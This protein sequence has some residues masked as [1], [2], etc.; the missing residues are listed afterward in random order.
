MLIKITN[1]AEDPE[2][3]DMQTS[4][5]QHIKRVDPEYPVPAVIVS[6]SGLSQ[7]WVTAKDGRKHILRAMSFLP[8]MC[9]DSGVRMREWRRSQ[10]L[11]YT[12]LG[13]T[14]ETVYHDI[15]PLVRSELL[16]NLGRSLA[17]LGRNMRGYFHQKAKRGKCSLKTCHCH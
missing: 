15:D 11:A 1:S 12:C 16:K 5:M 10:K 8:G 13:V 3:T 17:R 14:G 7:T 9:E 2:E 4:A 6:T